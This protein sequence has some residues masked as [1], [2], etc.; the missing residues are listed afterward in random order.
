[1]IK[2][3]FSLKGRLIAKK[4]D[5]II[6]DSNNLI[7]DTG[8]EYLLKLLT[9][10]T[11]D[12]E[13]DYGIESISIGDGEDVEDETQTDLQGTELDE[14]NVTSEYDIINNEIYFYGTI[15]NNSGST[16]THHEAVLT[17]NYDV[18]KGNRTCL[19]R[20]KFD[21]SIDLEDGELIEY[22]WLIEIS[23]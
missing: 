20:I 8:I 22:I 14:S 6:F 21:E 5:E 12:T 1:M 10:E 13:T 15:E 11:V 19:S 9:G 17:N 23:R 18:G 4:N 2:N 7:L 3:K 16:I